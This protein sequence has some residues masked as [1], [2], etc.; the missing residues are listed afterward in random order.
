MSVAL[1]P[2][3]IAAW[4]VC[5]HVTAG[6][7]PRWHPTLVA[8]LREFAAGRTVCAVDAAQSAP[9]ARGWLLEGGLPKP[10]C[11]EVRNGS[12]PVE[13]L[14]AARLAAEPVDWV[15]V[16]SDCAVDGEWDMLLARAAHADP[17]IAIASPL[18]AA[19]PVF[20][21]FRDGKPG[22]ME[23]EHISRWLPHLSH[24][25]CFEV[26]ES[27][28]FCA[29]WRA[30]A[31][32]AVAEGACAQAD[33]DD[34]LLQ[35]GLRLVGCDWVYVE[36]PPGLGALAPRV[37]EGLESF[38]TYHP[39]LRMRHGFG[40]AGGWGPP[41]VP[42]ATPI[43]KPVQLHIAHSWGGGLGRWVED[44]C[45]ADHARWNL[46]L[47]SI[48]TWG[49]FGQRIALYRSH[50]MDRPLRDWLLDMPI[51]S[52][53]ITHIQYRRIL[54]EI[55]RDFSIDAI[56]VSSLIG[57][58][59]DVLDTH[60]PTTV[61]AHDYTPFC[62]ALS[63]RFDG[64]CTR[65]DTSRLKDCFALNPLNRFFQDAGA[66]YWEAMRKHYVT[67]LRQSHIRIV[68]PS[69]SVGRHL[70]QL[71]PTLSNTAVEI[72]PHG[73]DFPS[74]P[75]WQPPAEGR[76]Q[77]V[78]L[79]SMAAQKGA[80]ILAASLPMLQEFADVHLLG[81][82]EEGARFKDVLGADRIMPRY[83][84][85]E[86]P[87]LVATIRPHVGL[88]LSVVPE[89]F[90]YTLSELWALGVPPVATR[91][92][93]FADRIDEGASGFLIEPDATALLQRLRALDANR[94]G[95]L[96]VSERLRAMPVRTREQM[97]ADYHRLQP[98]CER[99]PVLGVAP[100]VAGKPPAERIQV[101]SDDRVGALYIDRQVPLRIVLRDFV[102]YLRDKVGATPRMRPWRKRVVLA[103]L[104]AGSRFFERV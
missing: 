61:V 56:I 3:S 41:S 74:C 98:L 67:Q 82:G 72:I 55:V 45:E 88:L 54:D 33:A 90:S 53:A 92:G 16:R 12:S 84:R 44:Y 52:I 48:G 14:A 78:V 83:E 62:A 94:S 86:L 103:L 60:L 42:V 99:S 43:I 96:A 7:S 20:S 29:Y 35:R 11:L 71:V 101:V 49:A 34:A 37:V 59:L 69:A 24:G 6:S 104:N 100:G 36:A 31:L 30:L 25:H 58:S 23:V 77:L 65:C 66:Q 91:L 46:V 13:V 22:W 79:G 75:A 26:T 81:C 97:V 21:P 70:G 27:L 64:M 19:T 38:L 15:Y 4:R 47:R 28:S 51:G 1:V 87:Q 10:P 63:I 85:D 76:L 32:E 95:L 93:G 89:T 8:W 102:A 17:S 39:L 40:E 2:H 68:A 50:Q 18:T 57:H 5:V 73:M 9:F 80:D